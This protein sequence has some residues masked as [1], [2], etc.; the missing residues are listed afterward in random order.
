MGLLIVHIRTRYV[1]PERRTAMAF[2]CEKYGA[3]TVRMPGIGQGPNTNHGYGLNVSGTDEGVG[4]WQTV[5]YK[6]KLEE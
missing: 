5:L 3:T 1:L 4:N 2:L 6:F